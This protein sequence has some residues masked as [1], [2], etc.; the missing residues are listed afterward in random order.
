[1]LYKDRIE[2]LEFWFNFKV[3]QSKDA[4]AGPFRSFLNLSHCSGLSD[5]RLKKRLLSCRILLQQGFQILNKKA[6]KCNW[7]NLEKK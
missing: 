4:N 2:F 7:L 1:M 3:Y 6:K 5:Q